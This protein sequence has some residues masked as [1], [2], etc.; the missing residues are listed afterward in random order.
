[1]MPPSPWT[2]TIDLLIVVP[3]YLI[4]SRDS[5]SN[6]E[7]LAPPARLSLH[8][9]PSSL[10]QSRRQPEARQKV[11][12]RRWGSPISFFCLEGEQHVSLSFIP[13][14]NLYR[15]LKLCLDPKWY[16]QRLRDS[17]S[18]YTSL[19]TVLTL[20]L[21]RP[22]RCHSLVRMLRSKSSSSGRANRG[23]RWCLI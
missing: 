22:F 20:P 21:H 14:C 17:D 19:L 3:A 16:L 7:V 4:F 18:A 13:C 23:W 8:S 9:T 15:S 5:G 10:P 12:G 11:R 1:V 6:P 2:N